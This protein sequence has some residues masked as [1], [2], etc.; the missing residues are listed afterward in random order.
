MVYVLIAIKIRL[1]FGSWILIKN[2]IIIVDLRR[3]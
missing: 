3:L 1:E 2:Q